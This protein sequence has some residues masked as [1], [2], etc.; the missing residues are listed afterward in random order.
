MRGE[1][2]EEGSLLEVEPCCASLRSRGSVV[3]LNSQEGV[4]F[5]WVG[6]KAHTSS[7]EVGRRAVECLTQNRPPELGLSQ[8]KPVEVQEVEEGTEPAEF[9][10]ALGH[11]DRKAYDCMLQGRNQH[12]QCLFQSCKF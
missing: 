5:L 11:M 10:T 7:R 1:L 6:C 12:P 4:L 3:L 2:P 9:W 8:R